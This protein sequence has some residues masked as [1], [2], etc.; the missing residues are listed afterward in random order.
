MV[1]DRDN[2]S[3]DNIITN[4]QPPGGPMID[5]RITFFFILPQLNGKI[6]NRVPIYIIL[7]FT[8]PYRLL[9]NLITIHFS[10][11]FNYNS[12]TIKIGR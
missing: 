11:K 9:P 8:L 12:S 7:Q 10:Y 4:F 6:T 5:F 1:G 2:V 3:C